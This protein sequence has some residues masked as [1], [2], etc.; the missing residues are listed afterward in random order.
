VIETLPARHIGALLV[1]DDS[2]SLFRVISKTDLIVACH[3]GA[4]SSTE[5]SSIMNTAVHSIPAEYFLPAAIQQMLVADVQR[6]FVRQ[7]DE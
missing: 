3:H 1:M 7:I 5:A 2:E 4:E 6:L